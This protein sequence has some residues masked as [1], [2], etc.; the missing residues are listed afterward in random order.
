MSIVILIV[1][2]GFSF[3]S[4]WLFCEFQLECLVSYPIMLDGH[5]TD[6]DG[7][8]MSDRI[9]YSAS[10]ADVYDRLSDIR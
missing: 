7:V 2:Y 5:V 1:L 6:H 10:P 8:S 4:F 3:I 9:P